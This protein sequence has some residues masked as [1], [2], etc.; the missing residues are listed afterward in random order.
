[1]KNKNINYDEQAVE[2]LY[3]HNL[4]KAH[5][6]LASLQVAEGRKPNIKG[7]NGWVYEQTIRHCLCQELLSLGLSPKVKE[8][9]SL[10]GRVKID[11]LVDKVAIEIK[12]LGSFGNDAKKYSKYRLKVEEKGWTYCY[13]TRSETYPPYRL[14]SESTFGKE[15]AFFLDTDGDWVRFIRKVSKYLAKTEKI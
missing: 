3:Q 14:A 9:E 8:Q 13:L 10:Y 12:A 2:N 5:Q 4:E 6:L 7:L 15:R 11:L 1:M